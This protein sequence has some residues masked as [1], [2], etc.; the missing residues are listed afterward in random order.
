MVDP[1]AGRSLLKSLKA[2]AGLPGPQVQIPVASPPKALLRPVPTRE[3][4]L[5]PDD[6]RLLTEWRNRY[7]KVFL[8]EFTA[9]ENRTARWLSEVVGP[10]DGKILFMLDEPDGTTFGYMGLDFIDW[11]NRTGEADA[12]V[13]GK[14]TSVPGMMTTAIRTLLEWAHGQLGLE[15]LGVRV[16]SDNEAVEFYKKAGYEEVRRVP[17][18]SI[19]EPGMVRWVEDEAVQ[20]PAVSLIHLIYKHRTAPH[21]TPRD[22]SREE[23]YHRRRQ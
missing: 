18:R 11:E 13:R 2:A 9:T 4:L 20:Q 6:V 10:A 15:E 7:V 16:R 8:T 5:N 3:P 22:R 1:R 19:Q 14:P 12:I 23:Q 17:L 21:E